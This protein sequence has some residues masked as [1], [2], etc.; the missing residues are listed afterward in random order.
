MRTHRGLRWW[1]KS[2]VTKES[3]KETVKTIARG[4]PD[5]PGT[6]VVTNLRVFHFYTQGRGRNGRPAFPAPSVLR[7]NVFDVSLGRLAPREY[8]RVSAMTFSGKPRARPLPGIHIL[9]PAKRDVDG[10]DKPG[11]DESANH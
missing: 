10:R 4:M 11:H 5:E 9:V 2:P 3:A 8:S 7:A 1:Q 6:T